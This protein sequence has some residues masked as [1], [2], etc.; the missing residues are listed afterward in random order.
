MS[1]TVPLPT[2]NLMTTFRLGLYYMGLGIMSILTLG[3]LNRVMIQELAI[4]AST[5]AVI[6][7]S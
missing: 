5:T 6:L 7:S 1:Y 3:I 4:P 2:V